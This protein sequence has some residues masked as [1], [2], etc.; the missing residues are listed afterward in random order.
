MALDC[1]QGG[2]SRVRKEGEG[3]LKDSPAR[4]K[5]FLK[6]TNKWERY[7]GSYIGRYGGGEV[8]SG[9]NQKKRDK[10]GTAEKRE[11]F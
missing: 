11:S 8:P 5:A 7:S 10:N 1:W 2:R 9:D 3:R 4:E 6:R